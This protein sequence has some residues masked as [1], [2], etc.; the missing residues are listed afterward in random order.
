MDAAIE[1]QM[2]ALLHAP[3]FQSLEAAWRGVQWLIS[4]LELDE[5]LQLHLFD[6]TREELLADIVGAQGKLAQ[7]G[8]YR[9]LVD[10]WRNVPGGE[11]WSSLVGLIDFGPSKADIG[12]LAALGPDRVAGRRAAARWCRP[13]AGRRRCGRVGW[14]AGTAPQRSRAVDRTGSAACAAAPAVRKGKR[15]N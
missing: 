15:S 6:V 5:N 8:V 12:L 2:R 1:E 13:G 4:S 9:A 10:R 14:V 11:G 7:T 3:A